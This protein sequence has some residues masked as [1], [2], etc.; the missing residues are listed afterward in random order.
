MAIARSRGLDEHVPGSQIL[1]WC[2][3][4]TDRLAGLELWRRAVYTACR[5]GFERILIVADALSEQIRQGLEGDRHLAGRRWEVLPPSGGWLE[6]IRAAG[7]RWVVFSDRWIVDAAHLAE[8]AAA[9]GEPAAASADG[10]F[11]AD[12]EELATLVSTGWSPLRTRARAFRRIPAP[13]L[14]VRATFDQ[15]VRAAEDA[16]FA[17]LARDGTN[18]F[19]RYVDRAMSGAISRWLAPHPVTPN[20]ITIFSTALGLV[21]AL[22]LLRPT[23]GFGLLGSA[24]FLASTIIDGCDGEIARL[25]FQES[26]L[27]AKL[28]VVGDNLVHAVLFPCVALHVY[29]ADPNG[30]YLLL[31]GV[32]LAG[33][34]L[35]WISVYWVIV[36]G[37]PPP[38]ALSL[39]TLF[40]NREFAYLLFV[41]GLVGELRW[42]VWGMA[43]GLWV[44]PLVLVGL[45]LAER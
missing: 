29:F 40:G 20:Q 21:G 28:D 42:F 14:Y 6:G 25:K 36:R 41:L 43:I 2:S 15:D 34:V 30:P 27:G 16:L 38:L 45:R 10:P 1:V 31:G 7:G 18:P 19:A 9:R 44:F 5:A 8:L 35:S 12:S 11:S 37:N 39:F 32:A 26:A 23:Y 24:L 17:S 33:I 4:S 3:E 13:A 22:L